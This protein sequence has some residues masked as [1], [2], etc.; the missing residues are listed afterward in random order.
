M[1][2]TE[3]FPRNRPTPTNNTIIPPSRLTPDILRSNTNSSANI[4]W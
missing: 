3:L 1:E 2:K 4:I